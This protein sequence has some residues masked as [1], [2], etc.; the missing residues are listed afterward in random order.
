VKEKH[1]EKDIFDAIRA[2][3]TG[4]A[5][6]IMAR[7]GTD[8]TVKDLLDKMDS[9]FGE[10]GAEADCLAAFFGARQQPKESI[11]DWSC[12]LEQL[13]D[14]ARRQAELPKK[15]DVLLRNMLWTGLQ[16]DLKDATLYLYDTAQSFDS[17]RVALRRF[18]KSRQ[19]PVKKE[20]PAKCKAAQRKTDNSELGQ[21]RSEIKELKDIVSG[22][23][24]H[25]GATA[26]N[27]PSAQTVPIR[28]AADH[29]A[30]GG[31]RGQGRGTTGHQEEPTCHRCGQTGHLQIGCRV[32]TDHVRRGFGRGLGH[33]GEFRTRRR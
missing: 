15:P 13:L 4:K 3:L 14:A 23:T 5:G 25:L 27:N 1:Q 18:E 16:P 21:L 30:T 2:S 22:I 7:L 8:A 33:R 19:E 6:A 11:A 12:R 24:M 10:V 26:I 9:V 32:R 29:F 17:L 28:T 31:Y 20:E